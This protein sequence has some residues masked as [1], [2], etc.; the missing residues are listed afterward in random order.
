[1]E[2]LFGFFVDTNVIRQAS[3]SNL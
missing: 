3:T 2:V 1:M